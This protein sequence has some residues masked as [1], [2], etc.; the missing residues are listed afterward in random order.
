MIQYFCG[1]YLVFTKGY[2]FTHMFRL[3]TRDPWNLRETCRLEEFK[4]RLAN[5]V[6]KTKAGKQFG[7]SAWDFPPPTDAFWNGDVPWGKAR[8]GVGHGS[9][10]LIE[11]KRYC[12]VK[13]N[14]YRCSSLVKSKWSIFQWT[15][16]AVTLTSTIDLV[17]VVSQRFTCWHGCLQRAVLGSLEKWWV[18]PDEKR[19][20]L[21]MQIEIDC[22]HRDHV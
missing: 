15:F 16:E 20:R 17:T 9:W 18:Q 7:H 8:K 12:M 13:F 5:L 19:C 3:T 21:L 14:A 1:W 6:Q 11:K 10:M 4:K 2:H 22:D